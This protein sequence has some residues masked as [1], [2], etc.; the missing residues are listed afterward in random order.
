MTFTIQGGNEM[1]NI[2]T[3]TIEEESN[4]GSREISI[5]SRHLKNRK[6]FLSGTIDAQ[7]AD[8][9]TAQLLLLE[10]EDD[11][12]DINLYINSG[13]GEVNSGL[14]IYD[15]IQGLKCNVNLYAT[16]MAASMAAVIFAGG[17][18]GRRFMLEHAKTMIHEPLING[19]VGGSATSIK[20]IAD[21]II[22]T[23]EILNR[24]LAKHTGRTKEEIDEAT[25]FDHYMNAKESV[26][27]GLCDQ[28]IPSLNRREN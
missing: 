13:G 26:A 10:D 9:I 1:A 17:K 2:L 4:T 18:P 5:Y 19:G 25:R 16:G 23:R 21:S 6:V 27:F 20:N 8:S 22:E 3:P 12:K 7:M 28:I 11:S 15:V 14:L 24:I